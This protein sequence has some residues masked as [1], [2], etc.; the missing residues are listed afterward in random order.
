MKNFSFMLAFFLAALFLLNSCGKY[1]EGPAFSLS[2]KTSRVTGIWKYDKKFI[3]GNQT[4]L[5]EFEKAVELDI[6]KDG[7]GKA[8]YTI[9]NIDLEWEFSSDKLKFKYRLIFSPELESLLDDMGLS[10]LKNWQESEILRLTNKEFWLRDVQ[11]NEG[12]S[13]ETISHLLKI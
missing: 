4:E 8:V 10:Y 11:T 5:D 3:N 12:V 6:M 9:I 2:S 1:E 13:T 7:K